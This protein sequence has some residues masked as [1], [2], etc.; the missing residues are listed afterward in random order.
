MAGRE[1]RIEG[2]VPAGLRRLVVEMAVRDGIAMNDVLTRALCA[3][4][5]LN[6]KDWPVPRRPPGRRPTLPAKSG[7]KGK[8]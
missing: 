4:F 2:R 7:R 5:G 1:D 3:L 6:P 8:G